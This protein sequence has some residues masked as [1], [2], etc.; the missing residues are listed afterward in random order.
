MI[1]SLKLN[2]AE[3]RKMASTHAQP[4]MPFPGRDTAPG[5]PVLVPEPVN[6]ARVHAPTSTYLASVKPVL[7]H[8]LAILILILTSP[9]AL[10]V[11]LAI[12]IESRTTP[13]TTHTR[14]G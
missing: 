1:W 5:A 7:D 10:L 8:T 13:F 3:Y 2:R 6:A 11:A 9:I 14:V 12:T 4:K